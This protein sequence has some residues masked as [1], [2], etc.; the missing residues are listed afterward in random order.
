MKK[1]VCFFL[2]VLITLIT[3]CKDYDGELNPQVDKF[4]IKQIIE[5]D[6]SGKVISQDMFNYEHEKLMLWQHFN[7]D[8]N[9]KLKENW[10][11]VLDYDGE[12]VH[13]IRYIKLQDA[14]TED[15][16]CT[17]FIY[18]NLIRE[19]ILSR[20]G[21]HEC[22][23]CWKYNYEY[24]GLKPL[25]WKSFIKTENDKWQLLRKGEFVYDNCITAEYNNYI[26]EENDLWKKDYKKV[27]LCDGSKI[28]SWE[29]GSLNTDL[30]WN[31]SQRVE[32]EYSNN[33]LSERKYSVWDIYS[34][35]WIFFGQVNYKYDEYNYL[36][37]KCTNLGNKMKFIYETGNGNAPLFYHEINDF[38]EVEPV[39]KSG[40]KK[41]SSLFLPD[42]IWQNY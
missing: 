21:F 40:V 16:S 23:D 27:Y 38:A 12:S 20:H 17:Y 28:I 15:R 41:E 22:I 33:K 9:E 10:K 25:V 39:L 6:N 36:I 1:D 13:S 18:K 26:F 34:N 31:L 29:G 11:I 30:E 24:S 5:Y 19:V 7:Q 4:R 37:E 35:S 3:S 14:W 42:K 8:E 32:Y 2:C